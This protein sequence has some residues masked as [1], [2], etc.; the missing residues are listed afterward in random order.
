MKTLDANGDLLVEQYFI[1]DRLCIAILRTLREL[2][3][4]FGDAMQRDTRP[5]L[6]QS[7]SETSDGARVLSKWY[8]KLFASVLPM[9]SA[10]Q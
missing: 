8:V 4:V 6:P 9:G 1:I 2:V 5:R 7:A 10:S 3:A